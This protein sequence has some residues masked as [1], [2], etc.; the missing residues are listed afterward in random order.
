[1]T[2][3]ILGIR[4]TCSNLFYVRVM[5]EEAALGDGYRSLLSLVTHSL[6][7]FLQHLLFIPV[8]DPGQFQGQLFLAACIIDFAHPTMSKKPGFTLKLICRRRSE[9][10]GC[11]GSRSPR[12][13]SLIHKCLIIRHAS[14]V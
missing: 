2:F 9:L 12:I 4:L 5:K 1:M 10:S 6:H 13:S 8:Q 11:V 7:G 14:I 3:D